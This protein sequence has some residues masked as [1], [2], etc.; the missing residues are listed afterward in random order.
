MLSRLKKSRRGKPEATA[1]Q[2]AKRLKLNDSKVSRGFLLKKIPRFGSLLTAF[3]R[4]SLVPLLRLPPELRNLIWQY[5][6]RSD[7]GKF[8][9]N[10]NEDFPEPGLLSTCTQI[11]R[12]ASGIFYL[13]NEF[14]CTVTS[15]CPSMVLLLQKKV[16]LLRA[17]GINIARKRFILRMRGNPSWKNLLAWLKWSHK[18]KAGTYTRNPGNTPAQ[19]SSPKVSEETQFI[20]GLLA[21]T[22]RMHDQPWEVVEPI[23]AKLRLGLQQFDQDWA[24]N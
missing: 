10:E 13:E 20:C 23:L 6:L 24:Q 12:E 3:N 7:D 1:G 11:R 2:Q 22:L 14:L 15:Y 5:A 9:V 16:D 21:M 19:H 8:E 17:E 4:P 18:G